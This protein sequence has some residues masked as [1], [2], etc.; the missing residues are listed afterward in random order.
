MLH[1]TSV[2]SALRG[3]TS[4]RPTVAKVRASAPK[5]EATLNPLGVH[6]PTVGRTKRAYLLSL[7]TTPCVSARPQ[8]EPLL[9]GGLTVVSCMSSTFWRA[10]PLQFFEAHVLQQSFFST[11]PTRGVPSELLF[12]ILHGVEDG[13]FDARDHHLIRPGE[14]SGIC[15]LPALPCWANSRAVRAPK[16]AV[17]RPGVEGRLGRATPSPLSARAVA[18]AHLI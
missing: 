9:L 14:Q 12:T 1:Q 8:P 11:S 2:F 3:T 4:T 18:A 15:P 16:L 6:P 7:R 10:S 13:T 17:H 5:S